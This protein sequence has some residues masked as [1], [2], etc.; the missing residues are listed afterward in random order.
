MLSNNG[1][2]E[3]A[4]SLFGVCPSTQ[5]S[6]DIAKMTVEDVQQLLHELQLK[7][8]ELRRRE[9]ELEASRDNY[10]DFY[11]F[12]PVGYLAIDQAGVIREANVTAATLLGVERQILLLQR[13]TNFIDLQSAAIL[14]KHV[15]HV[16][17]TGKKQTCELQF[18]T[19]DNSYRYLMLDSIAVTDKSTLARYCRTALLDVTKHK[20]AEKQL[21]EADRRKDEF[22]AMLAH[23]LR[24]PLTPIL[25]AVHIMQRAKGD[26][27]L[28]EK[29]QKII[30]GQAHHMV[31]LIDD[32]LDLSRISVGKIQLKKERVELASI[33]NSVI[34]TTHPL[35][36]SY[37]HSLTLKLPPEQIIL[38]A[39]PTRLA[40]VLANI[41][42][43][44]AKY[45]PAMGH[46]WFT[47]QRIP[48]GI[49]IS[50][51]DTGIGI[52]SSVLP[53]I[54][55]LFMQVDTSLHRAQGGLGIG[56]ALA[57][58]LTALHGGTVEV[59]SMGRGQGSEFV[60]HLPHSILVENEP[61]SGSQ[62][63][64][65]TKIPP[66]IPPSRILVVDDNQ[67]VVESMSTLLNMMG[68]TVSVAYNG[69]SAIQIA[70]SFLPEVIFLDIGMPGM[71][72]YDVARQIRQK[73]A[74][75]Q[76]VLVAITGWGKEEDRQR[77]LEAG[78]DH[79]LTKPALWDEVEKVL[80]SISYR[81]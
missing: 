27:I 79:H 71:N 15:D 75:Q 17:A 24:N 22:L 38:E 72:G 12:A 3:Q 47:V 39:D 44:A 60:V 74:L 52:S 43:N 11:D 16:F 10:R 61:I 45:T 66:S 30:A 2:L 8:E 21:A 65:T 23:E 34:E 48:S 33:V 32:L 56:L 40:Q 5:A 73:S 81:V 37:R 62:K 7:N 14:Q 80:K 70:D 59:Y 57:K 42:N 77:A 26:N 9:Q 6:Q 1:E 20:L 53:H 18:V 76:V 46:I 19:S 49:S 28:Q 41:L 36:E 4:S 69:P 51:R 55:D 25:N 29:A 13:L 78:F 50:I 31:R 63:S 64:R 35:I 67:E 54:F 58:A 68:H